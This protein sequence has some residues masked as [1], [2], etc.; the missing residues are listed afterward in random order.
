MNAKFDTLSAAK[1]FSRAGFSAGQAESL[2]GHFAGFENNMATKEDIRS[3][4][5]DMATKKDVRVLWGVIFGVVVPLL[6]LNTGI[7]ITIAMSLF[8]TQ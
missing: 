6:L 2:A 3:I 8:Q 4:R 7:S 1:G 5:A